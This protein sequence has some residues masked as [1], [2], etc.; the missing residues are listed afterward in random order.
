M[1]S[2]LD[3]RQPVPCESGD[4]LHIGV[5]DEGSV[6]EPSP[7]GDV[8]PAPDWWNRGS[9]NHSAFG[10]LIWNSRFIRSS[11][12]LLC[13]T[14]HMVFTRWPGTV[15]CSPIRRISRATVQRAIATPSRRSWHQTLRTPYTWKCS[16]YTRRI[17]PHSRPS[18]RTRPGARCGSAS[19]ALCA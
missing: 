11:E 16:S 19:R 17:S 15:P 12:R 13:T 18:R 7:H 8:E 6:G 5:D 10:R 9:D 4:T 14:E 2:E 3:T 1:C